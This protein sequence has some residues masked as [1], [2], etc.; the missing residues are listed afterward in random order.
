[1]RE[2]PVAEVE[3]A[4]EVIPNDDVF[5]AEHS[6]DGWDW[7]E[8]WN[9]FG[10]AVYAATS[11]SDDGLAL[12][13]RWSQKSPRYDHNNTDDKWKAFRKTPPRTTDD[14]IGAGSLFYWAEQADP[15]WRDKIK[16]KPRPLPV[17]SN[18]GKDAVLP[19]HHR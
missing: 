4:V 10:L 12:F 11:G 18:A 6:D 8:A 7:W 15:R 2:A 9:N 5:L 3:A 19:P 14:G 1:L 17:I 13:H 16:K